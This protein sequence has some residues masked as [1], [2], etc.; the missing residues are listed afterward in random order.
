MYVRKEIKFLVYFTF[1]TSISYLAFHHNTPSGYIS[2][3]ILGLFFWYD[4]EIFTYLRSK[5]S[6]GAYWR[7]FLFI[8]T[9]ALAFL[10]PLLPI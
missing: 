7:R 6:D 5:Y 4:T 2:A 1:Y 9:A 8:Q 3:I 10:F